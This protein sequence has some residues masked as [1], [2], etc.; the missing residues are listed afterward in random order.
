[1]SRALWQW[2][3]WGGSC[4]P[5]PVW[6]ATEGL[7]LW[8]ESMG[9]GIWVEMGGGLVFLRGCVSITILLPKSLLLCVKCSWRDA[10]RTG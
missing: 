4:A 1:L 5:A 8:G 2:R 3:G 9:V 10:M 7:S 6:P